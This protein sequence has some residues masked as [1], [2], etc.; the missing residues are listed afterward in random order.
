MPGVRFVMAMLEHSGSAGLHGKFARA[1]TR[2][3]LGR[4]PHG[5]VMNAADRNLAVIKLQ[6]RPCLK[7]IVHIMQQVGLALQHLH[8]HGVVHG[9]L[10]PL[11]IVRS[12]EDDQEKYMLI[13]LDAAVRIGVGR[14]GLKYSS[15]Y[16]PPE[17]M[18]AIEGLQEFPEAHPSW[19]IHSYGVILFELLTSTPLFP[20]NAMND[21]IEDIEAK[22][23]LCLWHGPTPAMLDKIR[24]AN[25][26]A[27]DATQL[28]AACHLV[29]WCLQDA[30][31]RPTITQVLEHTLFRPTTALPPRDSLS[32]GRW[33]LTWHA[34]ISHMQVQ[35]NGEAARLAQMIEHLGGLPWLD[36][37]AANL[38]VEG[39]MNGV[40]NSKIFVLLLTSDV[41]SRPF[42]LREITTAINAGTCHGRMFVALLLDAIAVL[43]A[44]RHPHFHLT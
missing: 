13:D 11:N 34:F 5:I 19:D 9:D 44:C 42:C 28:E 36:M 43:V 21:N 24:K 27:V 26:G 22:R 31:A 15:A 29:E 7:R 10:K 38:T 41:L 20:R 6:E 14:V 8:D 4:Y 12:T 35:A 32:D 17:G 16:D 2:R 30:R 18:V 25:L 3:G 33:F 1:A 39:M 37:K 23:Q 40:C